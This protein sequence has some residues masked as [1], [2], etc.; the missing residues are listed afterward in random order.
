MSIPLGAPGTVFLVL[1]KYTQLQ[2]QKLCGIH[3]IVLPD[4]V[5]IPYQRDHT[6]SGSPA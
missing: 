5:S 6:P 2:Q 3:H 1:R 4:S